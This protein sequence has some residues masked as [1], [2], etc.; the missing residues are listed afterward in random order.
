MCV[1]AEAGGGGVG[2]AVFPEPA[3][4]TGQDFSPERGWHRHRVLTRHGVAMKR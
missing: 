2:A 1:Y 3:A 4:E